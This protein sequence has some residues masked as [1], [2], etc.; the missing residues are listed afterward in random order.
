M[1][2][3][4]IGLLL[5][6]TVSFIGNAQIVKLRSSEGF[7]QTDDYVKL[8]YQFLGEGKD[9]IVDN[10][11][12]ITY[13][14]NNEPTNTKNKSYTIKLYAVTKYGCD[15][16]T[17]LTIN[18]YP[19]VTALFDTTYPDCN[20]LQ[21][22][23]INQ[24]LNASDYHWDFGDNTSSNQKNPSHL[25]VN[26]TEKNKEFTVKLKAWSEYGCKDSFSRIVVV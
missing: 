24:S 22:T 4:L 7:V 6:C 26:E 19:K 23:L 12:P 17:S 21:T 11:K 5:I 13:V 1:K 18:V 15:D 25:F 3:I 20:P 9:T 8:H 16:S 14:Y 2:S 10:T